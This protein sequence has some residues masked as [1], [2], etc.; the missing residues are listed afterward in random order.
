M[1][2]AAIA[3][4]SAEAAARMTPRDEIGPAVGAEQKRHRGPGDPQP[5]AELNLPAVDVLWWA[6]QADGGGSIPLT[7][8]TRE[9]LLTCGFTNSDP[10]RAILA[11]MAT[12]T[13]CRYLPLVTNT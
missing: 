13:V 8:S 2:R 11:I 3:A 9:P 10:D 12:T 6:S 4:V 5:S 7:R 1:A